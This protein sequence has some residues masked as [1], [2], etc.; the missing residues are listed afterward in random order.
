M[1]SE[2]EMGEKQC[3][4]SKNLNSPVLVL[5]V[6]KSKYNLV[7]EYEATRSARPTLCA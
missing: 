6:V 3:S 5:V 7:R 2:I 4:G 1:V